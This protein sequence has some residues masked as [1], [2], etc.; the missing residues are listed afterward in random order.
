M[1]KTSMLTLSLILLATLPLFGCEE[2]PCNAC[3]ADCPKVNG[4]YAPWLQISRDDCGLLW[5]DGQAVLF[6]TQDL[7]NAGDDDEWTQLTMTLSQGVNPVSVKGELCETEDT[8]SPKAYRFSASLSSGPMDN[9]E[10]TVIAGEFM[11]GTEE[12]N[13]CG[14]MAVTQTV[15]NDDGDYESCS[16][17][18]VLYTHEQCCENKEN[19]P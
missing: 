7:M 8:E 16:M 3:K 5:N 2:E 4:G 18:A 19:C 15:K 12:E 17:S 10:T 11:V 9:Q 1:S 6:V 13:V 14:S